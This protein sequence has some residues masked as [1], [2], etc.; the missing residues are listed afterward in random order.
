MRTNSTSNT[1]KIIEIKKKSDKK[2]IPRNQQNLTFHFLF[3]TALSVKTQSR[4]I[5]GKKLNYRI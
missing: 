5:L 4:K 1:K 3:S 2:R